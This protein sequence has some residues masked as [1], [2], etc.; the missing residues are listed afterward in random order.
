MI[1]CSEPGGTAHLL[2]NL[3]HFARLR[4]QMGP[5]VS[6]AEIADAALGLAH[7]DMARRDDVFH[8]LRGILIFRQSGT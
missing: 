7:G 6:A 2:P 8:K 4:R 5:A 3:I 1:C